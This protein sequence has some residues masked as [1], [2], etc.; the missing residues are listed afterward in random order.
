M[1]HLKLFEEFTSRTPRYKKPEFELKEFYRTL[2][3]LYKAGVKGVIPPNV[4]PEIFDVYDPEG[5]ENEPRWLELHI[6]P[7]SGKDEKIGTEDLKEY[8]IENGLDERF[9]PFIDYCQSLFETGKP[10]KMT[11]DF[12]RRNSNKFEIGRAHV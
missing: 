10:E 1:K 11:L 7:P 5:F 4:D 6:D 8:I 12:V 3:K 9:L 2:K